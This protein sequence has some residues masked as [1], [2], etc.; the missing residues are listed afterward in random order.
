MNLLSYNYIPAFRR[1]S[2]FDLM[3]D[4]QKFKYRME[5]LN[6]LNTKYQIRNL[7]HKFNLISLNN[8]NQNQ[9]NCNHS[10]YNYS[11]SNNSLYNIH[12]NINHD[13]HISNI[14]YQSFLINQSNKT[15]IKD[16]SN[17]NNNVIN[18]DDEAKKVAE[19]YKRKNDELNKAMFG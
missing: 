7:P 3:D 14:L 17:I 13:S 11:P 9:F 16:T 1:R 6:S 19:Y 10:N 18:I 5:S 8:S 15:Q 2:F 12:N 4:E